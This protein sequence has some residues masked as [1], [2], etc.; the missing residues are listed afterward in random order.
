MSRR[1]L[2]ASTELR[3]TVLPGHNATAPDHLQGNAS[4]LEMLQQTLNRPA[5]VADIVTEKVLTIERL[6]RELELSLAGMCRSHDGPL[7]CL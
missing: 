3:S 5:G 4:A 6:A 2:Q 7:L 1:L